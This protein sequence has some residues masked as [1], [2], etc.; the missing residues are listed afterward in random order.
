[1]F[2]LVSLEGVPMSKVVVYVIKLLQLSVKEPR[3]EAEACS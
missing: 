1:M 2:L 3:A